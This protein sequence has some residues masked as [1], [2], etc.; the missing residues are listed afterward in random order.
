MVATGA[1]IKFTYEDYC[2]APEDK[3]YELHD[4]D[5]IL[6]PSPN[7]PHQKTSRELTTEINLLIRRTGIGEV[8]SAPFDVV[9]SDTDVVQPDV[10]FVSRERAHIVTLNNIQGAPDLVVE[11]LSPSTAHRDRTFKRALYARHGVRE[12]WLVNTDAHTIEVLQLEEEGYRTVGTYSA[13][14]T[15]TSPTLTGFSLKIDDIF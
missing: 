14:Q 12:F 13:G 3:R 9:L 7:Q 4:G 8:Y 6:V 2:N 11:V 1:R 5:L 15:L 10:I